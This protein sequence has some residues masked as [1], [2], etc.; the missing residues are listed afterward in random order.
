M[1][2]EIKKLVFSM[3]KI[4][5]FLKRFFIFLS[6]L[7]ILFLLSMFTLLSGCE[8]QSYSKY[9]INE[10][11]ADL[12]IHTKTKPMYQGEEF[13]SVRVHCNEYWHQ[14]IQSGVERI[15]SFERKKNSNDVI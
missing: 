6:V 8:H 10:D 7:H 14:S 11:K 1:I 13:V 15:A 9:Y 5:Y 2:E 3:S 4:R 12:H